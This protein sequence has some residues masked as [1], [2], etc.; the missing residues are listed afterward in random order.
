[1]L[2]YEFQGKYNQNSYLNIIAT[3]VTKIN[4]DFIMI[5]VLLI[6]KFAAIFELPII[7]IL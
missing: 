3:L 2:V 7:V 5:T 4:G 6:C 1:M